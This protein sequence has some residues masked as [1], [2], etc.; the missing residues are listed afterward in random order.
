[1]KFTEWLDSELAALDR[2]DRMERG[3]IPPGPVTFRKADGSTFREF[4]QFSKGNPDGSTTTTIFNEGGLAMM[5]REAV[6][7]AALAEAI[8]R[9]SEAVVGLSKR[10]DALAAERAD[11]VQVD[12]GDLARLLSEALDDAGGES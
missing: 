9:A 12:A 1:M 6:D 8:G 4:V 3:E 10:V 7:P 2:L 11:L 5:E